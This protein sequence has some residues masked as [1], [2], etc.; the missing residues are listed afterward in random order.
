MPIGNDYYPPFSKKEYER[1]HRIL[2]AGMKEKGLDCLLIYG[3]PLMMGWSTYNHSPHVGVIEG[4]PS[5]A[6]VKESDLELVFKPGL[7]VNF[8][9]FPV[10]PDL[11]KGVWVGTTCVFT[12]DGLRRI[13]SYPAN[14]LRVIRW[15]I[16]GKY[17][18]E[19]GKN[20]QSEGEDF[21]SG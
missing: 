18:L 20:E 13:H 19:R 17:I 6:F 3:A 4:S 11:K 10:T 5:E 21:R 9:A 1:R 8:I 12:E 16:F 15:P 14:K 2:R 7:C